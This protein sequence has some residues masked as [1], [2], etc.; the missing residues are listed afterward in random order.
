ML[1]INSN[2]KIAYG[3]ILVTLF[4]MT[5]LGC[6][7]KHEEGTLILTIKDG[8]QMVPARIE[9][10]GPDGESYFADDALLIGGACGEMD[11]SKAPWQPI[12]YKG[13]SLEDAL[14]AFQTTIKDR[15]MD[16]AHFYSTGQSILKLPSGLFKIRVF[17]GPEYNVSHEEIAIV[18]GNTVK[19]SITLSRF[20]NM[21]AKGWYSSDDHL[22]ISRHHK[23]VNPFILKLMQAEDIHVGN[24]L[25]VG[26]AAADDWTAKQYEHGENGLYQEGNHLI[27][28]GQENLRTHLLGHAITLG[29]GEPIHKPETYPLYR[30][31]W[32]QA[33]DQGALNGYGHYGEVRMGLDPGLPI[34]A[35]HNLMHFMEVLQHNQGHFNTWYNMLNLGFRITPTAGTDY[36]CGGVFPGSERFFTK[37]E[38]PFTFENWLK[39]VHAG[40]TFVTTGPLLEF[41]I[42]DQDIGSEIV[43]PKDGEVTIKGEALFQSRGFDHLSD[44]L[45]ALELVENGEVVR[46]FPRLNNSGKISFEIQHKIHETSWFALRTGNRHLNRTPTRRPYDTAHSAP[47]YVTLQNK[48]PISEHPRTDAIAKRWIASLDALATRLSKENVESLYRRSIKFIIGDHLP[49]QV[50]MDNRQALIDEIDYA[51]DFFRA[52]TKKLPADLSE[53]NI[54]PKPE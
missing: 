50:L 10:I 49:R 7:T 1:S 31:A 51:R 8:E 26:R 11:R 54:S 34:V 36:M 30:L 12:E 38:G 24:L 52:F 4:I 33:V 43:L 23:G 46:K 16:N 20:V 6:K 13:S 41:S 44:E 18:A 39:G 3:A 19:K 5:S 45:M 37:V 15:F 25:E 27:A 17:K 2:L 22:H 29:A 47:I 9:V 53:N 32:Q 35:P 40:R 42:N 48:P 21:P 28:S 14:A